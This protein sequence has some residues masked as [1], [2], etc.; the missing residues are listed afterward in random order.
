MRTR[1]PR[2]APP[3]IGL[4]GS[5]ATTATGRPARRSSAI[6]AATR[7]LLPAPGGPVIPMSCARPASGYRRRRAASASDVRFSTSVSSRERDRRSPA[8][9]ASQSAPASLVAAASVAATSAGP[10]AAPPS[11]PEPPAGKRVSAT[12]IPLAPRPDVGAQE[13]GD[14]CDGSAGA[15]DR[16]HARFLE[17]RHVLVGDDAAGGHEHVIHAALTQK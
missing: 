4:D 10:V 3:V 15:K 16:G 11:P 7:V 14:R 12:P 2:T 9:A 6:N 1:S 5:T 17:R 13:I 8:R